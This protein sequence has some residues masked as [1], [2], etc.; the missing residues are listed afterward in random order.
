MS[1]FL[2]DYFG[3]MNLAEA[4]KGID[5]S[6]KRLKEARFEDQIVFFRSCI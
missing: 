5:I 2:E 1:I 6:F 3:A 4:K